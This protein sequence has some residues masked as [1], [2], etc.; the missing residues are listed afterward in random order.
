MNEIISAE[1]V[2]RLALSIMEKESV[3]YSKAMEKLGQLKLQIVC[4]PQIA[5]S[6]MKQVC[7]ITAVNSGARAFLGGVSVVVPDLNI[8]NLTR[9]KGE[10]L[11]SIL[12][13]FGA[14]TSTDK[15]ENF[16]GF[17]LSIDLPADLDMELQMVSNSW[18]GGVVPPGYH[19]TLTEDEQL[20]LGAV[21]AAAIGVGVAFF[22]L[23]GIDI[24]TAS[25]PT[26]I[27]LW[28]PGSDWQI[29]P[30]NIIDQLPEKLW[31][32]GL[33]HL[34]QAFL[35]NFSL[36]PFQ[37]PEKVS[38]MLQDDD[39]ISKANYSAGLLTSLED[40]RKRKTTVARNWLSQFGFNTHITERR[41]DNNTVR[42]GEEPYIAVCGFDNGPSR[43]RL[44]NAGFDLV[45]EAGLGGQLDNFDDILIH[46]F[47]S[48]HHR[49]EKLW[50]T[51][52]E[53][54]LLHAK[55]LEQFASDDPNVVCG[56]LADTIAGK[57]ISTSFVGALAGALVIA[58]IVRAANCGPRFDFISVQTRNLQFQ[59]G[60]QE[61][62]YGAEAAR[63]GL[64]GVRH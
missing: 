17:T 38:I 8:R 30:D 64:I 34:G 43:R 18:Q 14:H 24:H 23:S 54:G 58:E 45:I 3:N 2:N 37:S 44:E 33:G 53:G 26:G 41:F 31:F 15:K 9:L 49:A 46:G 27:S 56:M 19:I 28:S 62:S 39:Y 47:P 50:E 52:E 36:L 12:S 10:T 51:P 13:S 59:Q 63:N 7:L 5:V 61:S 1:S 48:V 55:V 6:E 35:W 22:R 42:A 21:A 11:I 4:G 16:D 60:F 25:K 32:L 20:P 29:A 40:V 57:A